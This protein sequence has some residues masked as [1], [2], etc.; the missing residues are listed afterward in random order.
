MHYF[1]FWRVFEG[2]LYHGS[3]KIRFVNFIY[4]GHVSYWRSQD[5]RQHK[6]QAEPDRK[7]IKQG[8]TH[9]TYGEFHT[10]FMIVSSAQTLFLIYLCM[11]AE[12]QYI[13]TLFYV[14]SSHTRQCW[15]PT[16]PSSVS[17]KT[18]KLDNSK[19]VSTLYRS[20]TLLIVIQ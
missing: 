8:Y 9:F 2:L 15:I 19:H 11:R 1:S 5:S 20:E 3:L 4:S 14:K 16:G 17:H 13:S 18:P 6:L 12:Y 7:Y 10:V